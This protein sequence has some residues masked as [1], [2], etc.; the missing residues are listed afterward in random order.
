MNDTKDEAVGVK[1]KDWKFKLALEIEI[2]Q[3]LKSLLYLIRDPKFD[4]YSN[5]TLNNS[6]DFILYI[7]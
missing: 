3:S 1:P 4:K 5:Q 2:T 6:M 7:L